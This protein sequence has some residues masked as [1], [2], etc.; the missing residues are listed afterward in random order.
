MIG[1]IRQT[2]QSLIEFA[3]TLPGAYVDHLRSEDVMKV[4]K[5]V[6]RLLRPARARRRSP[7]ARRQA[8]A[9]RYLHPRRRSPRAY[10]NNS[11]TLIDSCTTYAAPSM[12]AASSVLRLT[13]LCA[14]KNAIDSR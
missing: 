4:N 3:L 5:K 6:F 9:Q 2:H 10:T 12:S 7:H 14:A 13:P 8:P 1:T 11:R